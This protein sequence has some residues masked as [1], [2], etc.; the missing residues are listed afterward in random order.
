MRSCCF[1]S[2][3]SSSCSSV[4]WN[5]PN[6]FGSWTGGS[7]RDALMGGC[8]IPVS[9]TDTCRMSRSTLFITI[10]CSSDSMRML[11][12]VCRSLITC[13]MRTISASFSCRTLSC[14]PLRSRKVESLILI[15]LLSEK[16]AL[17]SI[18]AWSLW[19]LSAS[20]LTSLWELCTAAHS[21]RT[22]ATFAS[23]SLTCCILYSSC[24]KK[25]ALTIDSPSLI[26]IRSSPKSAGR[27]S[28]MSLCSTP[29]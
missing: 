16:N 14:M 13:C 4:G 12:F 6:T 15:S 1:I 25:G 5:G 24:V 7:M 26:A 27:S 23:I 18:T 22:S 8:R 9:R 11:S 17:R 29:E 21:S 3:P 20:A 19:S 10:S 2:T 28:S